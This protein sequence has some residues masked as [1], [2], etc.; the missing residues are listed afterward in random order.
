[1]YCNYNLNLQFLL[2]QDFF[3]T[4]PKRILYGPSILAALLR[5]TGLNPVSIIDPFKVKRGD[6]HI[7][8][9]ILLT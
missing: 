2:N 3:E 4:G 6:L 5:L 1:M 9:H 7:I 8:R